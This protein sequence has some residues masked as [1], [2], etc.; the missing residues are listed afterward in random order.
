MRLNS[1][2]DY[3]S[4]LENVQT[5]LDSLKDLLGRNDGYQLDANQLLGVS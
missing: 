2:N 4:H 5:D 3:S 1:V